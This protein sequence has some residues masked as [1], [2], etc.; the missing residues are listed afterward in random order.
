MCDLKSANECHA[1]VEAELDTLAKQYPGH[2]VVAYPASAEGQDVHV[3]IA[4]SYQAAE[5]FRDEL[6]D[7]QQAGCV[8]ID[9]PKKHLIQML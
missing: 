1:A 5:H 2:V 3:Y 4:P 9:L 6:S 7:V 8:L